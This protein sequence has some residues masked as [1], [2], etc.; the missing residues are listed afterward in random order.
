M[1]PSSPKAR[2]R[3]ASDEP[4][5]GQ[6]GYDYADSFE[7]RLDEPDARTPEEWMRSAI[8]GAPTAMRIT[9]GIAWRHLLRFELHG[10]APGHL[11]G[12]PIVEST[13]DLAHLRGD[14]PLLVAHLIGRRVEPTLVTLTTALIYKRPRLAAPMW[15]TVGP[16]HRRIAPYLLERVATE[17]P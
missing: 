17:T 10:G 5:V 8:G 2:R 7:I 15:A 11:F 4:L 14:S 13:S 3:P 6:L 16:A 12:M 9:V 1:T